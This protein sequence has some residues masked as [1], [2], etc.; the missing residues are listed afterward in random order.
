MIRLV[1]ILGGWVSTPGKKEMPG[2]QT[3]WIGLMPFVRPTGLA[4]W[5]CLFSE[6]PCHFFWA[7]ID[8][9]CLLI[10]A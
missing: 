2:P 10:F 9:P 3:T 4:A 7:D 6:L 8:L 5:S 1:G